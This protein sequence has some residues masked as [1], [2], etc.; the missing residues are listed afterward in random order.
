MHVNLSIYIKKSCNKTI[1]ASLTIATMQN[2]G[3]ASLCQLEN[4]PLIPN[5]CLLTSDRRTVV[6]DGK[7]VTIS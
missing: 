1:I 5:G 7:L 3:H 4:L 2:E 6:L